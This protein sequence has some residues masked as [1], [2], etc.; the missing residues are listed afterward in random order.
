MIHGLRPVDRTGRIAAKPILTALEWKPGDLLVFEVCDGLITVGQSDDEG[1][2]LYRDGHLR[3]PAEILRA[4]DIRAGDGLLLTANTLD[5]SLTIFPEHS[6][7]A[8]VT[9]QL[10]SR[11]SGGAQ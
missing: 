6:V 8:M 10:S 9:H 1:R 7:D 11:L 3:V 5:K 4:A 2:R